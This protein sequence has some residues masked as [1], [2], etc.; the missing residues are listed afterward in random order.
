MLLALWP[1]FIA[2]PETANYAILDQRKRDEQRLAKRKKQVSEDLA[3][4]HNGTILHPERGTL[5]DS[6]IPIGDKLQRIDADGILGYVALDRGIPEPL[7]A[8]IT[9]GDYVSHGIDEA[10]RRRN[11]EAFI[12]ILASL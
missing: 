10:M 7:G 1:L 12:L 4:R 5:A 8:S 11:D 3:R 2:M 9:T 6:S